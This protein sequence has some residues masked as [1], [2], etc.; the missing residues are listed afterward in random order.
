MILIFLWLPSETVAI[1]RV[2]ERVKEGGH[3]VPTD[4]VKRRYHQGIW[5]F[6][7]LYRNIADA[8]YIL[9]GTRQPLILRV[10][11][12]LKALK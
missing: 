3:N 4:T 1:L 6:R 5:N 8:W 11:V 9:D 12:I 10:L 2:A 7:N